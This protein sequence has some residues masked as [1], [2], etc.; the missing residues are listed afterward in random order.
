MSKWFNYILYTRKPWN[1]YELSQNPNITWEIICNNPDRPW[2]YAL[3]LQNP[4]ITW[5]MIQ[6]D[7]TKS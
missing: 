4:D 5:E 7:P 3:L 6:S 2:D 1:Y